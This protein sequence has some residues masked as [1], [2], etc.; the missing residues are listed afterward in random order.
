M[1]RFFA[2]AAAGLAFAAPAQSAAIFDITGNTHSAQFVLPTSPTA[3]FP[4][5]LG[6]PTIFGMDGTAIID[7]LLNDVHFHFYYNDGT[8]LAV[9]GF[10]LASLDMLLVLSPTGPQLFTG[11]VFNPTFI[12]AEFDTTDYYEP[13][14][15]YHIKV[16]V[17]PD[18]SAVPEPASWAMMIGGFA[19]AGGALRGRRQ[20]WGQR[21]A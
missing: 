17:T 10:D 2:L 4:E 12:N 19:L 9:G 21:V 20:A 7:G 8:P 16:T 5:E 1:R 6:D 3:I 18:A 15:T 13:S 11:T 14:W